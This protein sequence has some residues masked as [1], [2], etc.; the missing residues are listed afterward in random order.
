M[1]AFL[2]PGYLRWDGFKFVTDPNIEIIGP[3]GPP[4]PQG[5]PGSGGGEITQANILY[6]AQ[7]GSDLTGDGSIG[8]PFATYGHAST[9]AIGLG[10][11]PPSNLY[12][13]QFSPGNYAENVVA[14]NGVCITGFGGFNTNSR[15]SNYLV[16]IN[17]LSL[18]GIATFYASF[19]SIAGNISVG[20]SN[21]GANNVSFLGSTFSVTIGSYVHLADCVEKADITVTDAGLDTIDTFFTGAITITNSVTNS[22]WNAF[23]GSSV[24]SITI[25]DASVFGISA[26]I[27]LAGFSTL[28]CPATIHGLYAFYEC[29]IE[30]GGT[31]VTFGGGAS[32]ANNYQIDIAGA[33]LAGQVL[34]VTGVNGGPLNPNTLTWTTPS[35]PVGAVVD[36]SSTTFTINATTYPSGTTF[37]PSA[38]SPT[39][40]TLPNAPSDG[41]VYTFTDTFGL[42]EGTP[43]TGA[44]L[45]LH[46]QGSDFIGIGGAEDQDFV[47]SAVYTN[48]SLSFTM[49]YQNNGREVNLWIPISSNM[50]PLAA[51]RITTTYSPNDPREVDYLVDTSGGPFTFTTDNNLY[52][53]DGQFMSFK[54]SIGAWS[55]N[56]FTLVSTSSTIE[57]PLFPGNFGTT[58]VLADSWSYV[59]Y[60]FDLA[61]NRWVLVDNTISTQTAGLPPNDLTL[62]LSANS[63]TIVSPGNGVQT[64]IRTGA[65]LPAATINVTSTAGFASTGTNTIYVLTLSNDT[66]QTITYTGTSGGNQFTGCSGGTGS[67]TVGDLVTDGTVIDWYTSSRPGQYFNNTSGN[68]V[69]PNPA[70]INGKPTVDFSYG[71]SGAGGVTFKSISAPTAL[72]QYISPYGFTFASAFKYIHGD[73][74]GFKSTTIASGSNNVALPTGTI[75][76]VDASTFA[77]AGSFNITIGS[78]QQRINYA[79]ISAN[80]L[81]G[82]T[83]GTGTMLTGQEVNQIVPFYIQQIAGYD[84]TNTNGPG[85]GLVIDP[86]NAANFRVVCWTAPAADGGVTHYWINST[87]LSA[88]TPHYAVVTYAGANS[89]ST[90]GTFTLYIDNLAAVTAGPYPNLSIAHTSDDLRLGTNG[91]SA[92]GSLGASLLEVDIWNRALTL[93]EIGNVKA[94][95]KQQ[96]GF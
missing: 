13:V 84:D 31:A 49:Q 9:V 12:M 80:Q 71:N 82:C 7:N 95:L 86:N 70:G 79:S 89:F 42:Y 66:V 64:T 46:T 69:L 43:P 73:N 78:T 20:T 30:G 33:G 24:G 44:A 93:S 88:A 85:F 28:N 94:W 81:L 41:T 75:N 62:N 17:S 39:T 50:P 29:T 37:V 2:I 25:N 34:T 83:G 51:K 3:A 5:P 90:T 76:V 57:N 77:S 1:G 72:N 23:G 6:V 15:S 10:A 74:Q 55:N 27:E 38:G 63:G 59:R 4:G 40:I 48:S 56:N 52:P 18:T 54:D 16:Q 19:L 36:V 67:L 96:G 60:M 35:A 87:A 65:A 92:F 21:L 61:N 68:F 58:I 47:T 8:K 91:N 11:A 32:L 22:F 14:K 45:T 26:S 53:A